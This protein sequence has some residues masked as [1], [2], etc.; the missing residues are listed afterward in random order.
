M[1]NLNLHLIVQGGM[2]RVQ[3]YLKMT[4]EPERRPGLKREKAQ[5]V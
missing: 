4:V 5:N 3:D 2:G 1:S